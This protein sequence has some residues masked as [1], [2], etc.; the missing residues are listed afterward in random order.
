MSS[1]RSSRGF[2]RLALFL[3][4]ISLLIGTFAALLLAPDWTAPFSSPKWSV[5]GRSL[6]HHRRLTT[7]QIEG[8]GEIDVMS[9]FDEM[10]QAQQQSTVDKIVTNYWRSKVAIPFLQGFG[11]TI[12]ISL[13]VYGI[14]R[15]IGWVI[16][17]SAAS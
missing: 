11:I 17:G 2:H 12:A 10:D 3:A 13:A 1:Q 4:A 14:V 16:G 15:A 6:E 7:I 5:R 8:I 9:P